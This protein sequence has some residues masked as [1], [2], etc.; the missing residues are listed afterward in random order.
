MRILET[1]ENLINGVAQNYN[2]INLDVVEKPVYPDRYLSGSAR[3][4]VKIGSLISLLE[5]QNQLLLSTSAQQRDLV[6]NVNSVNS[7]FSNW[8]TSERILKCLIQIGNEYHRLETTNTDLITLTIENDGGIYSDYD[9]GSTINLYGYPIRL[10]IVEKNGETSIEAECPYHILTGDIFM[11]ELNPTVISINEL[12]IIESKF[13]T[14][15]TE[16]DI[17]IYRYEISFSN[18]DFN[19]FKENILTNEGLTKLPS[20]LIPQNS[21][22]YIKGYAAYESRRFLLPLVDNNTQMGIFLM[23]YMSG[24]LYSFTHPTQ[25]VFNVR[26]ENTAGLYYKGSSDTFETISKNLAITNCIPTDKMI[27]W[28]AIKGHMNIDKVSRNFVLIPNKDSELLLRKNIITQLEIPA[29]WS[30]TVFSDVKEPDPV[31]L[32]IQLYPN[33]PITYKIAYN[34]PSGQKIAIQVVNE[35]KIAKGII[36]SKS[37]LPTEDASSSSSSTEPLANGD[38]YI[39]DSAPMG[40]GKIIAKRWQ[41]DTTGF[42]F[43][44]KPAYGTIY[45]YDNEGTIIYYALTQ[46]GDG[47]DAWTQVVSGNPVEKIIISAKSFYPI[48]MDHWFYDDY[49]IKYVTYQLSARIFGRNWQSTSLILKPMMPSYHNLEEEYD[50]TR[51]NNGTI[52]ASGGELL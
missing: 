15:F 2:N 44:E 12:P 36:T 25:E 5:P 22:T 9:K 51:Y 38:V 26:L 49:Q 18:S 1:I 31:D 27:L 34:G 28:D 8:V 3:F 6:F 4:A 30:T 52:Y 21:L 23:D 17:E 24:S 33:D 46:I 48:R 19:T 37:Q 11:I 14:S 10:R 42:W 35:A 45:A 29:N 7:W 41:E 50:D 32:Q 39:I 40:D 13:L 16:N 20:F 47:T 43:Y